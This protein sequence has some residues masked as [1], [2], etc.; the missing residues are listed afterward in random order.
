MLEKRLRMK[1]RSSILCK[2]IYNMRD[3]YDDLMVYKGKENFEKPI[4]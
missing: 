2:D 3:D 1:H 4:D